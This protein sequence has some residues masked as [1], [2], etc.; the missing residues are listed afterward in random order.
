VREH[1]GKK[2]DSKEQSF[3]S[4]VW[5]HAEESRSILIKTLPA[6]SITSHLHADAGARLNA[7]VRCI[8]GHS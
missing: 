2:K 3:V 5:E 6:F 4:T 8:R 7:G 1:I